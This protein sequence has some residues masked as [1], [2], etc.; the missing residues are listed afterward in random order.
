M[1]ETTK[2][3]KEE[4]YNFIVVILNF[5]SFLILKQWTIVSVH[6]T[7]SSKGAVVDLFLPMI[8][9]IQI[10]PMGEWYGR[11]LLDIGHCLPGSSLFILIN[12]SRLHVIITKPLSTKFFF[13]SFFAIYCL[14]ILSCIQKQNWF[15]SLNAISRF[16]QHQHYIKNTS[17]TWFDLR[18]YCVG[19]FYRAINN[20]P[21][22]QS[23][24]ITTKH[25]SQ[26]STAACDTNTWMAMRVHHE[27]VVVIWI[28]NLQIRIPG[29][30]S[31]KTALLKRHRCVRSI[32]WTDFYE[33]FPLLDEVC[34]WLKRRS[35]YYY[36]SY[37]F[38]KRSILS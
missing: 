29:V 7:S 1:N 28:S 14:N 11:W 31:N 17:I 25:V 4:G 30:D 27:R 35:P 32:R 33:R 38:V 19:H 26:L 34:G 36:Y 10:G 18:F 3:K 2:K 8:G 24:C 20:S 5:N 13:W 22:A 21:S 16:L 15:Y 6:T 23:S 9:S 37:Y 12:A